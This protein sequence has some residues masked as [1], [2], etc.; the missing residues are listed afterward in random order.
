MKFKLSQKDE[1]KLIA[2]LDRR[3]INMDIANLYND[4][5]NYGLEEDESFVLEDILDNLG[6][7]LS[8]EETKDIIAQYKVLD[9]KPYEISD[10]K[11]NIYYKL[12]NPKHYKKDNVELGYYQYNPYQLFLSDEI[13]VDKNNNYQEL[14]KAS[15][16]KESFSFLALAKNNNVWMSITPHEINTMQE[17]IDIVKGQVIVAGLGLGYYPF[18]VSNKNNVD[19]V[20]VLE[21]DREIIDLFNKNLL[22]LFP[23]KNKI[24]IIYTD[25]FDY[26]KNNK[27]DYYFVD[28]WHDTIDGLPL[29]IKAKQILKD[30]DHAHYWIEKSLI[31]GFRRLL[32][33]LIDEEYF[34][35]TSDDDYKTCQSSDEK[36]LKKL[37][38]LLK[39]KEINNYKDILALISDESIDELINKI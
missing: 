36:I 29:Y 17:S 25:A 8:D 21:K 32:L 19:K 12:I 28:L 10:Y 1:D 22:P 39:E 4:L 20:T 27:A 31:T 2:L 30:N 23:N 6:Y 7:D 15:Y 9:I 34:M 5:F 18:M 24:E 26:L 35:N 37:H 11:D 3:N 38:Y 33:C 14:I 16:F 13:I